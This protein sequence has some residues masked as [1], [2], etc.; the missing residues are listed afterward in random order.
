MLRTV[1]TVLLMLISTALFA[2]NVTV[3]WD[4]NTESDLSGYKVYYGTE[5]G[6]YDKV[7]NVGNIT[8][9]KIENLT[10]GQTYYFVVTAYDASGNESSFSAE[11]NIVVQAPQDTEAPKAPVNVKV[12]VS[13]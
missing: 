10:D 7:V 3:S 12:I 2:G 5:S 8:S 4:A 1:L 6:A 13:E 11:V 9:Q